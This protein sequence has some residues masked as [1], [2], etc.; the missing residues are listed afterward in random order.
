MYQFNDMGAGQGGGAATL[1]L[2]RS[3]V[4]SPT[5]PGL[6]DRLQDLRARIEELDLVTDLGVRIGSREWLRGLGTCAALSYA[7][8]SFAPGIEPLHGAT[9]APMPDAHWEEARTLAIAPLALGADT[10]RRMAP[11]DAVEPLTDTPERPRID[12]L[13]TLGRGDGLA[14]VLERAGVAGA[15]AEAVA[16]MVAA[17]IT[18]DEIK[19]GTTIDI[20]LGRRPNK[21]V[22]RPLEALTFRARFDLELGVERMNGALALKRIP[23]AVDDTPL[24]I[25]GKVGS[26]LYR[27]ARAAGAPAK[28]IEAYLRAIATQVSIGSIGADDEFDIIIEH[29]R[30][31]TGETET[32]KLLYAA[33]ERSRGKDIELMQWDHGGRTQWFEASGVGKSS[34]MLQRPV[35]G[36]VTSNFGKRRHPIL[37]YTRMHKGMDF[38]AGHGTPILAATDGRVSFAGRSGGYGKQVRIKHDGGIATSYSHMSRIAVKSGERVKQGEVIGY[39]GSTGLSTGPHLHYELYRNGVPVNPASVKF[40]SRAQLSGRDLANFRSQLRRLQSVPVAGSKAE[41]T[42]VADAGK[43]PD[44]A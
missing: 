34:G 25:Q 37:G 1:S 16:E 4:R 21:T 40:T 12:L 24:R 27:A 31:A 7:A 10:G 28:A 20:T 33:L 42:A 6:G 44:I 9:P 30:A 14:R 41:A 8:W 3:I 36:R 19:P 29:R 5:A 26:S 38:R 13:A 11:T 23:I 43:K 39:V 15:E 2:D 35:P 32:G 22:A 17:A 18:L